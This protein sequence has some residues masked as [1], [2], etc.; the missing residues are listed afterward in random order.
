[1]FAALLVDNPGG[2]LEVNNSELG[3][4]ATDN[5]PF[6]VIVNAGALPTYNYGSNATFVC[7][8]ITQNCI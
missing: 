7:D 4:G 6:D 8:I 3:S 5:A 2:H 1:L